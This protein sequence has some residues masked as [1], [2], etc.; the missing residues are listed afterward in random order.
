MNQIFGD[1]LEE[2]S[3]EFDSLEMSFTPNDRSIKQR[4]KN[5]RLSAQ[6]IAEYFSA[7]L[8]VDEDDS[9]GARR[10]VESKGAVSYVA[11]ELI[12]NA[13]KFNNEESN[14][15]IKIGIYFLK[16][17][18]IKN[19]EITALLFATNSVTP[20]GVDKFQTFLAELLAA[21]PEE[22]YVTQVEKSMEEE[23][24]E[25]SGL[26]FLTMI[27]DYSVKLGWK[28]ETIGTDLPIH[29]VTTMARVTV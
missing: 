9:K 24:N 28:F 16:Y 2:L 17:V 29:T 10:I 12:E 4:W 20:Q 6:F 13:M 27:N 7:F 18:S 8:P 21:D 19:T 26:G 5:N 3:S 11:N 15:K 25:A 22:L 23:H 1:Y 14:F